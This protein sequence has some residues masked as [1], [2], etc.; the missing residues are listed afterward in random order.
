MKKYGLIGYPL[1]HSFSKRFFSEKFVREGVTDASYENYPLTDIGQFYELINAVPGLA[2][3]NVTIPYKE[4]VVPFLS[5]QDEIVKRIG[6]CNCIKIKD[7]QLCGFN[8]DVYGFESSLATKLL[9]HHN[10]ALILGTGGASKA[11]AYVLYKLGISYYFVSRKENTGDPD[12]L[13]YESLTQE[14]YD[15][16]LLIINT[17]PVGMHPAE[18]FAPPINYS[19]ITDKHFL[20]DL[21]YNPDQT[22]FLKHGIEKGATVQNGYDMLVYQ[23]EKSWEIWNGTA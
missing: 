21:I 3:L 4:S 10:K 5:E 12:I 14:I 19:F 20:F 6:A 9:H 16:F 2:G 18:Q 11:V 13:T 15:S 17:S 1:N 7:G 22:L 8:T 23:A